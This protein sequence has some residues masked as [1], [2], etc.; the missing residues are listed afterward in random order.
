MRCQV[1]GYFHGISEVFS[2][3]E[4][5]HQNLIKQ[6]VPEVKLNIDDTVVLL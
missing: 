2:K 4:I 6:C 3:G 5:G 1:L